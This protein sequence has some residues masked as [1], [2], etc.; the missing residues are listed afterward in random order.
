MIPLKAPPNKL[1]KLTACQR[2][3]SPSDEFYFGLHNVGLIISASWLVTLMV[4]CYDF[5]ENDWDH[6]IWILLTDFSE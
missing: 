2:Q 4:V 6:Y 5:G 1:L 3:K